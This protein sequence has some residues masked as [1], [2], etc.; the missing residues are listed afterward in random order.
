MLILLFKE[1]AFKIYLFAQNLV[2][3]LWSLNAIITIFITAFMHTQE[4]FW[5]KTE[6]RAISITTACPCLSQTQNCSDEGSSDSVPSCGPGLFYMTE[7]TS[8]TNHLH[9]LTK[10]KGTNVQNLAKRTPCL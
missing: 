9:Y 6:V 4:S 10:Q 7:T 3:C 5:S 2:C 8:I 1:S